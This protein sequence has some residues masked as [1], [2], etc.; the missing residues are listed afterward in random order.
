MLVTDVPTQHPTVPGQS[1]VI[2]DEVSGGGR[3]DLRITLWDKSQELRSGQ[4]T[5]WDHCFELPDKHLEA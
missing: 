4:Y 1:S 2:Y 5:L 3:E